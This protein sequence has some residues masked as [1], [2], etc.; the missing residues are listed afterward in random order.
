MTMNTYRTNDNNTGRTPLSQTSRH[1]VVAVVD[2]HD[3][4]VK[5]LIQ[6]FHATSLSLGL[7]VGISLDMSTQMVQLCL[8]TVFN[9]EL[10]DRIQ[11][12]PLGAGLTYCV[13]MSAL[14][15]LVLRFLRRL[16]SATYSKEGGK[17]MG[18]MVVEEWKDEREV[19]QA[20]LRRLENRFFMGAMLGYFMACTATSFITWMHL[21]VAV[22][23][24][25]VLLFAILCYCAA[26]RNRKDDGPAAMR[27]IN[28]DEESPIAMDDRFTKPVIV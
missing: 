1:A 11:R 24:D 17:K 22:P 15:F 25:A 19:F 4:R 8:L 21:P 3:D 9:R 6:P 7:S 23:T 18:E 13:V 14:V 2:Q 10:V 27:H 20:M 5:A 26:S 28:F 12:H 16:V